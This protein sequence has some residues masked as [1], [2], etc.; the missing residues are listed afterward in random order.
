[1]LLIPGTFSSINI[2]LGKE[3]Y[4]EITLVQKWDGYRPQ[5][6]STRFEHVIRRTDIGH[7]YPTD[8][9][10]FLICKWCFWCASNLNTR[11][12]ITKCPRCDNGDTLNSIRISDKV[13]E[14][15]PSEKNRIKSE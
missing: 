3:E 13:D 11:N 9:M 7:E 8:S 4:E 12:L 10:E 15:D 14:I 2:G 6:N 1:M 5:I